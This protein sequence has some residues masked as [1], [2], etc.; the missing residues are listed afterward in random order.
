MLGA[1]DASSC[2]TIGAGTGIL[3]SRLDFAGGGG[4]AIEESCRCLVDGA[5]A[6]NLSTSSSFIAFGAL[7]LIASNGPTQVVA[8]P[9]IC[10]AAVQHSPHTRWQ[11]VIEFQCIAGREAKG[12]SHLSQFGDH[13]AQEIASFWKSKIL[14]R[15]FKEASLKSLADSSFSLEPRRQKAGLKQDG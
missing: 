10:M 14:V 1:A 12:Y 11:R 8:S 4:Q 5:L 3:V 13:W 2:H 7:F 9:V 6:V 15:I